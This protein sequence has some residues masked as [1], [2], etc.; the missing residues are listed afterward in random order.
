L[1]GDTNTGRRT[2]PDGPSVPHHGIEVS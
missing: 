2:A 1:G